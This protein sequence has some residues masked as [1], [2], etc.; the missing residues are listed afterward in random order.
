MKGAGAIYK[1]LTSKKGYT[2]VELLMVLALLSLGLV[3][4]GN[5]FSVAYR[6]FD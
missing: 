6:S 1:L 5:L 3:A 2:I 4:L